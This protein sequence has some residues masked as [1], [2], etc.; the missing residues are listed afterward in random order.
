M[1]TAKEM[2]AEIYKVTD[3]ECETV[4][5]LESAAYMLALRSKLLA[6]ITATLL[7]DVGDIPL[8]D[9]TDDEVR[10]AETAVYS[11]P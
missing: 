6:E 10:K 4:R 7:A 9:L 8:A 11:E 5:D 2:V 3:R 1:F